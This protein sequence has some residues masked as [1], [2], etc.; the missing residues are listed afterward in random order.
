MVDSPSDRKQHEGSVPLVGGIALGISMVIGTLIF[1]KPSPKLL[2]MLLAGI[3]LLLLGVVDNL[4]KPGVHIRISAQ[5]A[6]IQ[7]AVAGSD[8]RIYYIGHLNGEL[9]TLGWFAIL[10]AVIGLTNGYNLVDGIDGLSGILTLVGGLVE[11]S[12]YRLL[13]APIKRQNTLLARRQL[14]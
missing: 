9:I 10:F 5:L 6:A 11:R 7:A 13:T 3:G 8:L 4:I 1:L 14:V 2:V 12:R